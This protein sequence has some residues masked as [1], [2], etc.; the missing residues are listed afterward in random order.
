M[1][2]NTPLSSASSSST[3]KRILVGAAAEGGGAEPEL[4][5]RPK[6]ADD[7]E[8]R[9]PPDFFGA[10]AEHFMGGGAEHIMA[11]GA[12]QALIR[13]MGIAI[14][15]KHITTQRMCEEIESGRAREQKVK[16][17]HESKHACIE[18]KSEL[19]SSL[20]S[21]NGSGTRWFFRICACSFRGSIKE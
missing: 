1:S 14:A 18:R 10:G 4:T 20:L 16:S 6:R 13:I 12:A 15:L 19:F 21:C 7:K 9:T 2:P 11:G 3:S 8:E 5:G 17:I